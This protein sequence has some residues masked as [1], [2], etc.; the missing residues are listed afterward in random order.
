MGKKGIDLFLSEADGINRLFPKLQSIE[1]NNLPIIS[2]EL[3]LMDENGILKDIYSIEIHPTQDYPDHFPHVFETGGKIPKNI[4]WHVYESDGHCCI[5]TLSE[6]IL[7]CKNGITISSFIENE[8]K[9]YFFNQTFRRLQGYFLNERSHGVSGEIETFKSILRTDN[10]L[11]V[12]Q[13][14]LFISKRQEPIRVDKCFCGSSKYR[15]CH[16]DAYRKLTK[17][18]DHELKFFIKEI[19]GSKEFISAYSLS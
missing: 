14:L 16:R 7:T 3:D 2:G 18:S 12:A 9:P 5:K 13:W 10:I 11:N 6:E 1:K 19:I 8:V 4:D 15:Q 17:F